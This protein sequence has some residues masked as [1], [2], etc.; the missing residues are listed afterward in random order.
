[1][2]MQKFKVL[3]DNELKQIDAASIKML[4]QTGVKIHSVSVNE[5][6]ADAGASFNESKGTTHLTEKMVRDALATVPNE[7]KLYDRN[8]ENPITLGHG[9]GA[10]ASGHNATF[11]K[12]YE[13]GEYRGV[14]KT[15]VADFT[16]LA[17]ALEDIDIVGIQALPQ[18]VKPEA[19]FL[20]AY[21]ASVNNTTKH[22]FFSPE[23]EEVV[24]TIIQMAKVACGS[25]DLSKGSPVTCQLSPTS[26]LFWEPGAVGGVVECAREKVPLT[27]LPQPFSGMTAPITIAGLL[28]QH[29]AETLSGIVVSQLTNPG[30]PIIWGSAWTTFDMKKANVIICSPEASVLRVAGVQLAEYYNI[31]SHTIGPDA[32]AHGYDQQLGWEKMMSTLSALGAGVDL[33]V[34]AGMFGTGMT[35][36]YEQL[37]VDAEVVSICRRFLEGISVDDNTLAVDIVN[38]VGAEGNFVETMHTLDNLRAGALWEEKISNRHS[39]EAWK[40]KGSPDVMDNAHRRANAILDSH[41]C[42]P[43]GTD[44]K[45]ELFELIEKFEARY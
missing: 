44:T 13:T 26:P 1:M 10:V 17:D 11:I 41:Q 25:N 37:V 31:P 38:E 34:N 21:D 16:K 5:L 29:N 4:E 43:L 12:D 39:C 22:I 35:V 2:R 23:S 14:K 3:S 27:L 6:L 18:D 20:H 9:A 8:L 45:K 36:S 28:A 24:K 32:D 40:A 42:R 30:A 7:V 33:L 19:T 15:E